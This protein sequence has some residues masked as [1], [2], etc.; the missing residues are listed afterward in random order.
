M[1]SK[2]QEV[3]ITH[4]KFLQIQ[5]IRTRL[6]LIF[7]DIDKLHRECP[8]GPLKEQFG[9]VYD[10][11]IDLLDNLDN[12]IENKIPKGNTSFSTE[13]YGGTI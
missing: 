7:K 3:Y 2:S 11:G 4:E 1:K 12:I 6:D 5:G 9:I 10:S 13:S 8:K